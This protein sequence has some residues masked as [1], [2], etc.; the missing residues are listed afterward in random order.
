MLDAVSCLRPLLPRS[1]LRLLAKRAAPTTQAPPL[2]IGVHR[3]HG[4]KKN[5]HVDQLCWH[6]SWLSHT[7]PRCKRISR[8][9]P[10][11]PSLHAALFHVESEVATQCRVVC[12]RT[13]D[14]G[15]E[16]KYLARQF[17]F[18]KANRFCLEAKPNQNKIQYNAGCK[19]HK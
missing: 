12:A 5:G 9:H 15:T 2:G 4:L 16:R 19:M 14:R 17:H 18:Q 8:I 3:R 13:G 7:L 11:R 10:V 1:F 6:Q